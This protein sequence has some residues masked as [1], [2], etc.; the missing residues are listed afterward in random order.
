MSYNSNNENKNDFFVAKFPLE[1][2]QTLSTT[3]LQFRNSVF[4][5]CYHF[6]HEVKESCDCYLERMFVLFFFFFFFL[7]SLY[8]HSIYWLQLSLWTVLST[9]IKHPL[10]RKRNTQVWWYFWWVEMWFGWPEKITQTIAW[11]LYSYMWNWSRSLIYL[12]LDQ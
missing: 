12:Y 11:E 9:S 2:N 6:V 5:L 10:T 1:I 3:L 4:N 8:N 7:F